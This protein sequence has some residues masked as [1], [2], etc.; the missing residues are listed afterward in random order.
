[1]LTKE[2]L[3]ERCTRVK[4]MFAA[5]AEYWT[6]DYELDLVKMIC[7]IRHYAAIKKLNMQKIL[8]DSE[9]LYWEETSDEE[10]IDK[11]MKGD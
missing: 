4:R 5:S 2:E 6:G 9:E 10:K 1:M 8:N 11:S 3:D 7:D